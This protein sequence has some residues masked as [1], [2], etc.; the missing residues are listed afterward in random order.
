MDNGSVG[1][2]LLT[3]AKQ[4]HTTMLK[5]LGGGGSQSIPLT[6]KFPNPW[7]VDVWVL[8]VKLW[9]AEMKGAVGTDRHLDKGDCW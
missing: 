7:G 5:V 4:E 3:P 2:I 6:S 9:E 8:T 1:P